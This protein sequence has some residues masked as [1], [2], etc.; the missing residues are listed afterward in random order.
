MTLNIDLAFPSVARATPVSSHIFLAQILALF[1][2][3]S[4]IAQMSFSKFQV[5]PQPVLL[6]NNGP[7][8]LSP[9]GSSSSPNP[10]PHPG[11]PPD[12]CRFSFRQAM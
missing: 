10:Y 9:D 8:V 2:G 6:F 5:D 12:H 11:P 4:G 7:E 1:P 3:I